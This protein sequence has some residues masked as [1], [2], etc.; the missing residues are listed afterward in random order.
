MS[1]V[2]LTCPD[3]FNLI[4]QPVNIVVD[5]GLVGSQPGL[6][7]LVQVMLVL[8]AGD[9]RVEGL[10]FP[11]EVAVG[12]GHGL[13]KAELSGQG[14]GDLVPDGLVNAELLLKLVVGGEASHHVDQVSQDVSFLPA[15]LEVVVES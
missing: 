4:L 13:L 11:G 2:D 8:K 1:S 10:L 7:A 15:S 14:G 3:S 6:F 5:D 12:S 9:H